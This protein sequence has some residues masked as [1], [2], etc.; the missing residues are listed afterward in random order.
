MN[1]FRSPLIWMP[2][3]VLV[4]LLGGYTIYWH[5]LKGDVLEGV[6]DWAED[7]R[8]EG[9]AVSYDTARVMGFPFKMDL[10]IETLM[11]SDPQHPNDWSWTGE[12]IDVALNPFRL[13]KVNARF[14]GQHHFTYVDRLDDDG[15]TRN[16]LLS[17]A[18]NARIALT[19]GRDKVKQVFTEV[20]GWQGQFKAAGASEFVSVSAQKYRMQ[21]ETAPQDPRERSGEPAE[22]TLENQSV[23]LQI[24]ALTLPKGTFPPLGD[25]ISLIEAKTEMRNIPA[26]FQRADDRDDALRRWAENDGSLNIDAMH[27]I[28]GD[29]DLTAEGKLSLDRQYR[30]QGAVTTLAGGYNAVIDGLQE[31]GQL[32]ETLASLIKSALNLIALTSNDSKGRLRVLLD[33]RQ[34]VLYLGPLKLTNLP[35]LV[36]EARN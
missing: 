2:T 23:L 32:D 20:D 15:A 1:A 4:V 5:S 35:P 6:A 14:L 17:T 11:I 7:R 24:E 36:S 25:Q 33:M 8:A 13:Q 28:W 12:K 26:D 30:L 3:L 31:Q 21:M 22:N 9:M 27:M 18:E 29:L 10:V 16:E 19:L 34:G